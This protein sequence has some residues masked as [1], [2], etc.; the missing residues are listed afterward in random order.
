MR[1]TI[2]G[3][4]DVVFDTFQSININTNMY[5]SNCIRPGFYH[6][7]KGDLYVKIHKPPQIFFD[8]NLGLTWAGFNQHVCDA[9]L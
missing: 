7:E 8:Y 3:E 1:R 9:S 4:Q 6:L 2:R 5:E